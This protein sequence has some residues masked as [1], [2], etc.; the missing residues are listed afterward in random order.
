MAAKIFLKLEGSPGSPK[1]KPTPEK[2]TYAF[3]VIHDGHAF[4]YPVIL[5]R[6][7][8][9]ALIPCL[10]PNRERQAGTFGK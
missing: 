6:Y 5:G 1:A 7:E 2:S 9:A 4:L 8:P 10:R 3:W